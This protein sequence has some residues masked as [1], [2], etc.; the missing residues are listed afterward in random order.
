MIAVL[1]LIA[2]ACGSDD[3]SSDEASTCDSLQEVAVSVDNLR[4]VDLL[5]EGTDGLDAAMT[6]VDETW[7]A[8]KS[9][10]ED[11]FGEQVDEVNDALDALSDTVSSIG[12]ADSLED[13]GDEL[14]AEIEAVNQSWEALSAAAAEELADC[15]VG[16]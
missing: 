15:E 2:A 9:A 4:E 6:D 3:D 7:G 16:T 1:G 10:A 13:F 11:Q 12:D 5:A 14:A 8:A